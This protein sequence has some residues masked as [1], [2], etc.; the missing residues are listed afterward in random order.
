MQRR[1]R[2]LQPCL[3]KRS[4]PGPDKLQILG[5][6]RMIGPPRHQPL[7]DGE[8]GLE[9]LARGGE[10]ACRSFHAAELVVANRQIAL[11][12]GIARLS[13]GQACGDGMARLNAPAPSGEIAGRNLHIA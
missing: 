11:P 5:K 9:A 7:T 6:Q 1:G 10:V 13:S 3:P 2:R 8:A 12:S 4:K